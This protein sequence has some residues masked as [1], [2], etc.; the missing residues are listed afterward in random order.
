MDRTKFTA[1]L[2]NKVSLRSWLRLPLAIND[3][4]GTLN[5]TVLEC[6]DSACLITRGKH[7]Q[8]RLSDG[9][10]TTSE[11]YLEKQWL[12]FMNSYREY[13]RVI[14]CSNEPSLEDTIR[15]WK[16]K[17]RLAGYTQFLKLMRRPWS[18]LMN[19]RVKSIE[20]LLEV[21]QSEE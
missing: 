3:P 7:S 11:S 18:T 10:E 20:T 19:S 14:Q 16:S 5:R 6:S 17:E 15:N 8:K 9:I 2:G 1:L 4:L 21:Y 13:N 12:N